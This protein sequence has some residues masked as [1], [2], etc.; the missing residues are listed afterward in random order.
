MDLFQQLETLIDRAGVGDVEEATALLRRLKGK[1]Q[2]IN[3]AVDEFML[4]FMT[5][6]FVVE[7]GEDEFEQPMRALVHV[8]L[9]NLRELVNVTA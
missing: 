6:A 2:A 4:D 5:L 9:S 7:T 8:R 3:G 1:S